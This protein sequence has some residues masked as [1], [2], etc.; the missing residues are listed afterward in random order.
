MKKHITHLSLV[1]LLAGVFPRWSAFAEVLDRPTGIKIGER[2]TLRP[3]VSMSLTYDSNPKSSG[4]ETVADEQDCLW[5]IAPSLSLTYNAEN[6]SL[7]LDGYYN[8]RQ[9]FKSEN[10]DRY[11]S[12]NYGQNLRWNW[13]DST[14]LEKSWSLIIGESFKQITMA[15][16]MVLGD[17]SNYS[18]D[19]RQFQFS[20]AIQRRFNE[21]IHADLNGAYYWLD[22][23]NDTRSSA[24]Y[25]GWDRWMVGAEI[26]Y[27]ASKW[28]DFIISGSYQGYTQ[29]NAENP[30][31]NSDYAGRSIGDSSVGYSLQAGLGSLLTERVSYRLLAGWSRFE[32]GDNASAENG[33]VYTA[34][35]N[36]KI[37]ETW[38][39]MLLASSYYQPSERQYASQSRVDAISWGLAKTMVR[40]KLRATLDLRY[41]RETHEYTIDTASDNDY[42]L[43][44]ITGR[45]GA[46]YTLN[47]FLAVF[48]YAE[49]QKNMNDHAEERYE[50]YDYGRFRASVGVTLS[51]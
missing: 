11:N 42:I 7:L 29:K 5:T 6:W 25:Y 8:W 28:T 38:N 51:Y 49:Y 12:H 1:L 31:W 18:S 24:A 44:I 27:T 22:Y 13:T 19:S 10:A 41:R 37:G 2:M 20:A 45:L 17:G 34:S 43:N 21:K 14:G 3:Y 26:G 39:T 4:G 30:S 33:F 9:Y 47:R 35:G 50:A 23:M 36:W 40:G 48:A 16:D 46:N 32:Y 15:D